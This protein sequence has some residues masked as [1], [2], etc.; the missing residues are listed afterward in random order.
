[1]SPKTLESLG[2]RLD[3]LVGWFPSV[4]ELPL[5]AVP[6]PLPR[7]KKAPKEVDLVEHVEL[8]LVDLVLPGALPY[9]RMPKLLVEVL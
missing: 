7:S 9:H 2:V 1:M 3:D 6:C 5:F 4:P 8:V